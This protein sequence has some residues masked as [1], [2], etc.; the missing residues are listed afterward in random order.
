[1]KGVLLLRPPPPPP[2]RDAPAPPLKAQIERDFGSIDDFRR[3]LDHMLT[4]ARRGGYVWL[5]CTPGG[6]LR[7]IRTARDVPPL[8]KVLFRFP[9]HSSSRPP[10]PDWQSASDRFDEH[11][12]QRPPYP[13]P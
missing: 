11:M 6:R 5:V 2:A 7:L 9:S 1:M 13:M 8:G 4:D 10:K 12:D 3:A